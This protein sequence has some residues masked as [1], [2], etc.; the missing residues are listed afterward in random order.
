MEASVVVFGESNFQHELLI[1]FRDE[2][3]FGG[4]SLAEFLLDD[5]APLEPVATF[6]L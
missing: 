3:S 1:V 2:Q 6:D 5:V 4:G